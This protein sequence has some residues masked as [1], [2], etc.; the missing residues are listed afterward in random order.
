MKALAA[1]LVAVFHPTALLR[2]PALMAALA[3]SLPGVT[4]SGPAAP[5]RRPPTLTADGQVDQYAP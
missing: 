4:H 3:S 5:P 2:P 1:A